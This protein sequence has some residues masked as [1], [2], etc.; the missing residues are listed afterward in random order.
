MAKKD[1]SALVASI[2][3]LVGGKDNISYLTHC[4]TRLRL[5][6][7]DRALVRP[8]DLKNTPGVLGTQWSGD[9]LICG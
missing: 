7:K 5:N 3:E 8:E 2:M 9:Q 6:L 4:A 1:H